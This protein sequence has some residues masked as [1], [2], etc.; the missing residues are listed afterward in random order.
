MLDFNFSLLILFITSIIAFLS[1]PGPVTLLVIN[2]SLKSGFSNSLKTIVGTNTASLVLITISVLVIEGLLQVNENILTILKIMGSLYLI[3]YAIL[4]IKEALQ[5][6][7]NAHIRKKN[8][9]SFF[10]EGF[11]IGISN[12]KDIIFFISFFPQFINLTNS[13]IVSLTCLTFIWLFLDYFI[14]AFFAVTLK[15]IV[16]TNMKRWLFVVSGSL[17]IIIAMVSIISSIY[18]LV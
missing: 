7:E 14:L 8:F 9:T 10:K 18:F 17:F 1:T 11:I 13:K 15:K 12:P 2:T 6:E 5:T 4:L 16:T 3:Y